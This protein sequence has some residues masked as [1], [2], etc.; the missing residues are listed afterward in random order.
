M[1]HHATTQNLQAM[2]MNSWVGAQNQRLSASFAGQQFPQYVNQPLQSQQ[3]QSQ[4][5]PSQQVPQQV[6]KPMQ[7]QPPAQ[8]Q[9]Q[10]QVQA[11]AQV[12]PMQG[13]APAAGSTGALPAQ[14]PANVS[15]DP[16]ASASRIKASGS[17]PVGVPA[18]VPAPGSTP[19]GIAGITAG[20][21]TALQQMP[22]RNVTGSQQPS[23]AA[24]P[25]AAAAA[26]AAHQQALEQRV[27]ELEEI[28]EQKDVQIKELQ[29]ALAKAGVKATGGAG[30]NHSDRTKIKSPSKISASGFQ[31]LSGSKPAVRYNIVDQNDP[32]DVRLEEFYNNTGSAVQFRR[33]NHGFYRF[34]ETI[35]ELNIINHK[36]MA[37]TEDG[38]NRGKFGPIEKFLMYY[39]NIEREKAGIM[40]EA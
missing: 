24:G 40:P 34:G 29:V 4:Q 1:L 12:Q 38:W 17:V 19:A 2:P 6:Q 20:V 27:R 35:V 30:A 7:P 23:A 18:G 16:N 9:P 22:M 5:L 3:V 25:P 14:M 28:V 36:L 13:T 21:P 31:K 11:Q 10:P 8:P 39:E 15:F 33:I 37:R 32:I 26:A